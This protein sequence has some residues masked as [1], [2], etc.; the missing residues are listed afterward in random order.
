MQPR[1]TLRSP[2]PKDIV[3]DEIRNHQIAGLLGRIIALSCI[4]CRSNV[5]VGTLNGAGGCI[6]I[7]APGRMYTSSAMT[8]PWEAPPR[9]SRR[10][11]PTDRNKNQNARMLGSSGSIDPMALTMWLAD[12][13]NDAHIDDHNGDG[14]NDDDLEE[15]DD[16]DDD[17]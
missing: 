7:E 16:G 12:D 8:Q 6:P 10:P 15:Q 11:S 3:S 2:W 1:L 4:D 9:K 5:V 17:D 13:G 14:D